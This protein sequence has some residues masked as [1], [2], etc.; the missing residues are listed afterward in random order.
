MNPKRLKANISLSAFFTA[1]QSCVGTVYFVT[2]DGD[3]LNMKTTLSQFLFTTTV[4][5]AT[6]PVEGL[7]HCSVERDYERLKEYLEN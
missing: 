5:N 4:S 2:E 7:I 3:Q 1:A 6:E